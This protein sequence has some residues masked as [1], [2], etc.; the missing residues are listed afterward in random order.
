AASAAQ[1]ALSAAA[2]PLVASA[3]A[4][5][6]PR[7]PENSSAAADGSLLE[8]IV[9]NQLQT[10]SQLMA[11]Q[12]ET[13]KTRDSATPSAL[14]AAK[15]SATTSLP[16]ASTAPLQS[17][18]PA[19]P[20]DAGASGEFKTFG[21]YKPVQQGP[22]GGLTAQQEKYLAALITRYTKRTAESKRL[23]QVY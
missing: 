14:V 2:A 23:T 18:S 6:E 11:A 20:S 1:L 19:S 16:N 15:N 9:Q 21:P 5:A 13:L 10:M 12:L 22:R 8:R 7:V 3:N 4:A 17:V